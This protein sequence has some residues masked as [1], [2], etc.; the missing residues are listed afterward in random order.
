ML[1]L[2]QTV[3][4]PLNYLNRKKKFKVYCLYCEQFKRTLCT[5]LEMEYGDLTLTLS[6]YVE[7]SLLLLF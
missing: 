2:A 3:E 6:K 5:D 1:K 7:M 4:T